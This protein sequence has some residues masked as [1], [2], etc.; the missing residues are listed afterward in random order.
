LGSAPAPDVTC[1]RP[2]SPGQTPERKTRPAGP[3]SVCHPAQVLPCLPA[4]ACRGPRR[5]V[6]QP[7][8]PQWRPLSTLD[9]VGRS[10]GGRPGGPATYVRRTRR[11]GQPRPGQGPCTA[12]SR[13]Q[14]ITKLAR[15]DTYLKITGQPHSSHRRLDKNA[16]AAGHEYPWRSILRRTW[17]S[18]GL[19]PAINHPSSHVN[20]DET[21]AEALITRLLVSSHHWRS[22]ACALRHHSRHNSTWG[23]VLAGSR[24]GPPSSLFSSRP[25]STS[26]SS[27]KPL[28]N[29]RTT[30]L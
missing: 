28:D 13:V 29:P 20:D 24:H 5:H 22:H 8:S 1:T 19:Q 27:Q 7:A 9:A 12:R 11:G 21:P 3:R 30:L 18:L 6:A 15:L 23:L 16:S 2:T 26:A 25:A 14:V 4:C 10:L 17:L